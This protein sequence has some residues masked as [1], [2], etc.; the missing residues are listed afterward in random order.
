M[1]KR[2]VLEEILEAIKKG[3]SAT[4]AELASS[5]LD[6]MEQ[7]EPEAHF[8]TDYEI[9]ELKLEDAKNLVQEA[10]R[11][12]HNCGRE[13]ALAEFSNPHGRVAKGELYVYAIDSNGLM[14][15]HPINQNYIGKDFLRVVDFDGKAFIREILTAVDS[16]DSGWIEYKWLNPADGCDEAKTVYFEKHNDAIICSG[17]YKRL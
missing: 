12:Y 15:A 16:Q 11:F 2:Q 1:L 5:A 8:S 7:P 6:K 17:I 3:D 10:I 4:A 9:M 14:L 13:I